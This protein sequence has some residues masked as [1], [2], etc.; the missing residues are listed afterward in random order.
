MTRIL[1][2]NKYRPGRNYSKLIA[3]QE[4]VKKGTPLNKIQLD[5][6]ILLKIKKKE[7]NRKRKQTLD[8]TARNKAANPSTTPS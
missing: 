7:E 6:Q 8:Q 3:I 2:V 4:T 1:E 5:A